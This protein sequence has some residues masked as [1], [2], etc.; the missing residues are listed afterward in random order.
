M[1]DGWGRRS[2]SGERFF[3]VQSLTLQGGVRIFEFPY[4]EDLVISSSKL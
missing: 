3:A 4:S 1:K 2:F